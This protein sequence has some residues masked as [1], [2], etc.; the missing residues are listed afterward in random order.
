MRSVI[1]NLGY[2]LIG[3]LLLIM[4]DLLTDILSN[5]ASNGN[6]AISLSAIVLI[7]TCWLIGYKFTNN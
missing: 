1:R 6:L 7:I 5:F 3:G 2:I 4:V